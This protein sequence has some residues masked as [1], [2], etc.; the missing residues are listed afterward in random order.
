VWLPNVCI[1]AAVDAALEAAIRAHW[2][3]GRFEDAATVA[4][5]G[6]GPQLYRFL[7]ARLRSA[8]RADEVFAQLGEDLWRGIEGL[9]WEAAFLT[10]MYTLARNAVHRY[11]RTPSNQAL[12]HTTPARL[13]E[14]IQH[15]RA[16]TQPY[17][18]TDVKDRFAQLRETLSEDEQTLLVLRVDR[19]LAW[20]SIARIMSDEPLDEVA[21]KRGAGTLRQRFTA[22]KRKLRAMAERDGLLA[23][24][25]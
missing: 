25:E 20:E 2:D 1:L 15:A 10:W 9:R 13:E 8:D 4:I 14:A 24:D 16:E 19:E 23:G 12:R 5:R 17:L 7:L 6:Y 22:L 11:V 18:R 21:L 3:A